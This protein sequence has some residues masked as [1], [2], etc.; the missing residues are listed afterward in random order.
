MDDFIKDVDEVTMRDTVDITVNQH[1][2]LLC[3]LLINANMYV[4]WKKL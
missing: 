2:E 4:Q 3:K 1:V